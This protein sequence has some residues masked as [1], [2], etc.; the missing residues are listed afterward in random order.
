MGVGGE[1]VGAS[2]GAVGVERVGAGK[3]VEDLVAEVAEVKGVAERE[4]WV[5]GGKEEGEMVVVGKEE[6]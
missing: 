2:A 5:E 3:A 6:G 4:D 1:G